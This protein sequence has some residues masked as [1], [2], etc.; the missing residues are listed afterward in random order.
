M[1]GGT[2]FYLYLRTEHTRDIEHT[3]SAEEHHIAAPLGE[4]QNTEHAQHRHNGYPGVKAKAQ[5][6]KRVHMLLV[7]VGATPL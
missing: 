7:K 5:N 3:D 1:F 2:T 6:H 4:Q